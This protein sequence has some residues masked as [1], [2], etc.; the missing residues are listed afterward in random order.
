MSKVQAGK[1]TFRQHIRCRLQPAHVKVGF[2]MRSHAVRSLFAVSSGN[3]EHI[4]NTIRTH[5]E[6]IAKESSIKTGTKPKI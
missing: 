6:G 3:S 2:Q 5:P 1:C 4:A